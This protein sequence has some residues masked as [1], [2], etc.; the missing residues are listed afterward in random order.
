MGVKERKVLRKGWFFSPFRLFCFFFVFVFFCFF[1]FVV[2][3]SLL[4]ALLFFFLLPCWPAAVVGAA[5]LTLSL[6]SV[7][8]LFCLVSEFGVG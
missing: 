1:F 5:W 7:P 3:A 8:C 2:V 4:V 6:R